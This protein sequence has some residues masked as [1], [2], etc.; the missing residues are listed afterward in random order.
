[1]NTVK[2]F[3]ALCLDTHM[4]LALYKYAIIIIIIIIIIIL[5]LDHYLQNS[6]RWHEWSLYERCPSLFHWP[7]LLYSVISCTDL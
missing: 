7:D 6:V 4:K 2:R 5:D 1:M 3:W